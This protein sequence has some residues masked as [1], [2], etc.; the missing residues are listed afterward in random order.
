MAAVRDCKFAMVTTDPAGET[1]V[2]VEADAA[3][4]FEADADAI[5]DFAAEVRSLEAAADAVADFAAEEAEVE[6]LEAAKKR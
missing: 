4:R 5:T 1:A 6:G 3:G 2:G